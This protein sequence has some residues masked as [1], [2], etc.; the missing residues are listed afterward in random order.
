MRVP[1]KTPEPEIER[2]RLDRNGRRTTQAG[3]GRDR[4]QTY[5]K[6][7]ADPGNVVSVPQTYNQHHGVSHVAAMP[8]R[9]AEWFVAL[10]C[11]AGGFVV[12]PFAGSGTTVVAARRLGRQ[13]GGI[14][15]HEE[16]AAA[17][18]RRILDDAR[19][20]LAEGYLKTIQPSFH[21][22]PAGEAMAGEQEFASAYEVGERGGRMR[23]SHP[24]PCRRSSPAW[25]RVSGL[26]GSY[27]LPGACRSRMRRRSEFPRSANST[28]AAVASGRARDEFLGSENQLPPRRAFRGSA[29]P[30]RLRVGPLVLL[31]Q[32]RG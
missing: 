18:Q 26:R 19:A 17:A 2:R 24:R 13:A 29:S 12:D 9:L 8:E 30:R 32:R 25:W 6:G 31:S 27:C 11:P 14:E 4:A 28:R 21:L 3:H 10:M 1:Y 16:Y 7:G 23:R 20:L 5:E 22:I 15:L